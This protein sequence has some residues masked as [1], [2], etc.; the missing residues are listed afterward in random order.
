MGIPEKSMVK[1]VKRAVT[2]KLT[3][4]PARKIRTIKHIIKSSFALASSLCTNEFA[5]IY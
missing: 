3:I 4:F 1:R 5:T 2:N